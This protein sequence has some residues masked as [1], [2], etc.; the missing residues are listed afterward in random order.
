M[1][2][3]EIQS[4]DTLDPDLRAQMTEM[5]DNQSVYDNP[6]YDLDFAEIIARQRDDAFVLVANDKAGLLGYWP[7]HIRP[8]KWA[9]PIG[10]PFS[11]WHGPVMR[12]GQV[13][14]DPQSFLRRA[15]LRG[16]TASGFGP[17]R[18]NL[19]TKR[20][21]VGVGIA[22]LPDGAEAYKEQMRRLHPKHFKN[23]RRSSRMIE[24]DFTEADYVMD[25]ISE[26]AFHWLMQSKRQQF[27]QTGKHDV[28][29]PAWVQELMKDLRT[30]RYTRLRGRLSTLRF[31]G[32][33]AAAEF[34]ILSDTV[35][36]GWITV[37]D[38]KFSMYSPG[39][40]LMLSVICDMESTG[41]L[42]SDIGGGDHAYK[43]Y[44]E[45]YQL[46]CEQVVLRTGHGL[47]PMAASWRLAESRA[48]HKIKK[49]M[50][51]VR[52][53]SD[54]IFSTELETRQRLAGFVSALKGAQRRG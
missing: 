1:T 26:D 52:R 43:K 24:R 10:A 46:P 11:D 38:R 2:A 50:Q 14:L 35:V 5:R 44:Y 29:G 30:N 3:V 39:H 25:D 7:L 31:D 20:N 49:M 4:F 18:T 41:H 19:S 22:Y 16:L 45:S 34:D 12:A 54:Q 40:L 13:D 21:V 33:L 51:S 17:A 27:R 6:F 48:P 32:E 8:G 36:H 28:L 53:R 15:G 23:L 47:R 42:Y 9:R 37:Y